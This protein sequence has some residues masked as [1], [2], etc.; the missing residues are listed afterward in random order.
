[1]T[2]DRRR[3]AFSLVELVTVLGIMALTIAILAPSL[4]FWL[5]SRELPDAAKTVQSAIDIVRMQCVA[6]GN[7]YGVV[8][9]ASA[10]GPDQFQ[11]L[12]LYTLEDSSDNV[13][14]PFRS[15]PGSVKFQIPLPGAGLDSTKNDLGI[16]DNETGFITFKTSGEIDSRYLTDPGVDPQIGLTGRGNKRKTITIN[17]VTGKATVT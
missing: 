5:R 16:S 14:A 6:Q 2:D 7:A 15:L 8:M 17:R 4:M 3:L 9:R 13:T 12:G 11:L 1:M 10:G